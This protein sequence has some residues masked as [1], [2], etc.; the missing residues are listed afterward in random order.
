MI[1]SYTSPNFKLIKKGYVNIWCGKFYLSSV[2]LECTWG[3]AR[4][5]H[6]LLSTN[7]FVVKRLKTIINT[8]PVQ[9]GLKTIISYPYNTIG[10]DIPNVVYVN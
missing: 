7:F 4:L 9:F 3:N 2:V 6:Y 1:K 8:I 5:A 10:Y